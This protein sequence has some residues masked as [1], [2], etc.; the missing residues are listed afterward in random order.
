MNAEFLR[1]LD[2]TDLLLKIRHKEVWCSTSNQR[3]KI[4]CL[5]SIKTQIYSKPYIFNSRDI[6]LNK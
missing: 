6:F 4:N 5:N 3:E 2:L 1:D